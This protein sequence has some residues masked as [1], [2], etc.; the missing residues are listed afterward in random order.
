[1]TNP[2]FLNLDPAGAMMKEEVPDPMGA[3]TE[4]RESH[5]ERGIA[6][7]RTSEGQ[8]A[9]AHHRVQRVLQVLDPRR[10]EARR[11]ATDPEIQPSKR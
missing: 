11:S 9:R 10:R 5:H 4:K 2:N 7:R 8:T 1:M 3:G 6:E